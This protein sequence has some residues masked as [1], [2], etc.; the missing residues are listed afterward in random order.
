[1]KRHTVAEVM[2]RNVV[3]VPESA[4]YKEIV[5]TLANHKV[6]A[7]PV[8]DNEG[9]VLGVVSEAD[10]LFKAEYAGQPPSRLWERKRIRAA[11]TKAGADT[12]TDLMTAPAITIGPD[13][14]V[15]AA[16]KLMDA[17]QVKR[18]PVVDANGQLAGI[19][20]RGDVL[21][22]YLRGD[23]DI[24]REVRDDVLLRT[25]WIDPDHDNITVEVANGVVTLGGT[26]DRRSTI[27]LVVGFVQ[28]VAG[29]VDVVNHLSY[30]Y[31]DRASRGETEQ[32]PIV[33]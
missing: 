20:S 32:F 2:T 11:R 9:V 31:D 28:S 23:E 14:R 30:H 26:L 33:A 22:L 5:E 18:L 13:D 19:V 4:G 21:R 27:G 1:M 7:V 15:T 29:V 24:R 8:V 17:E 3:S 12:A 10:L 16:A 25:L 6:S